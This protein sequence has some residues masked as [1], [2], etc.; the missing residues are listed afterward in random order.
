MGRIIPEIDIAREDAIR[1]NSRYEDHSHDSIE[2]PRISLI[3]HLFIL[4]I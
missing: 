2:F 3:E 1:C 4:T